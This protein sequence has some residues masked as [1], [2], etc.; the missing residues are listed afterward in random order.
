MAEI[1]LLAL[2]TPEALQLNVPCDLSNNILNEKCA[3]ALEALSVRRLRLGLAGGDFV[4]RVEANCERVRK[5]GI[6]ASGL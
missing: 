6:E 2:Q 4:S 5:D 1:R 3:L